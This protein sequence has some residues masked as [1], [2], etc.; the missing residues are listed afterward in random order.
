MEGELTISGFP[1]AFIISPFNASQPP[2]A[3]ELSATFPEWQAEEIDALMG[4]HEDEIRVL[5]DYLQNAGL[6][7]KIKEVAELV[8]RDANGEEEEEVEMNDVEI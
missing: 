1:K 6:E 4:D 5:N 3:A 7:R 2:S 8:R